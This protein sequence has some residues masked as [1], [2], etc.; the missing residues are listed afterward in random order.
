MSRLGCLTP[1]GI[2]AGIIAVLAVIVAAL[3]GGGS[4]FSP[5]PLNS[6]TRVG[7]T[8]GGVASHAAIGGNCAACHTAPWD[9]QGMAGACL[10]CHTDI[11]AQLASPSTLH[12]ALPDGASCLG[13]HT[14]HKG[15]AANLTNTDLTNSFP[16]EQLGF[17]LAAHKRMSDGSDFTCADCHTALDQTPR[18]INAYSFDQA[19]CVSC[20]V[21]YQLGFIRQHQADFGDNCLSCHDGADRYSGFDHAALSFPLEGKHIEVSCQLCHARARAPADFKIAD[22]TCLA[23]HKDSDIH[24]GAYGTDC[25][26]CHTPAGWDQVTF[27]HAKTA[28]PLTGAHI[29]AT[30]ASCHSAHVYKGTPTSC[31][32][33]HAEPQEHLGQFGTDCATCHVTSAW[34]NVIFTHTFPLNHGGRGQ[35][36]CATCHTNPPPQQYSTYTCYECHSQ[37]SV[38]S[39]HRKIADYTD[40]MRCHADGR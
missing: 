9:S 14:E 28:F 5:G 22:S 10:T 19:T 33:C 16:H 18:P 35:I 6:Q 36:A 8:L 13:C 3:L 7:V 24:Q 23:C 31:V 17:S 40:C 11:Q 2:G 25:A 39:E 20:H 37:S 12:G 15:E 38:A 21:G 29:E 32:S 27:D 26:S 30:C 34:E 4:M 1:F